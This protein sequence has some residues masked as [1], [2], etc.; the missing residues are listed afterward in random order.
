[1]SASL[2]VPTPAVPLPVPAL[3]IPPPASL[4]P[5]HLQPAPF[6]SPLLTPSASGQI[7]TLSVAVSAL[8]K[9]AV[10]VMV[11]LGAQRFDSRYFMPS[12][13]VL[14]TLQMQLFGLIAYHELDSMSVE[15][16]ALF[17]LFSLCCVA[18][19][20]IG[21]RNPGDERRWYLDMPNE[22]GSPCAYPADCNM[23]VA[24]FNDEGQRGME[25]GQRGN[26][27]RESRERRSVAC[28]DVP[29]HR[30]QSPGF[31]TGSPLAGRDTLETGMV[32]GW[33][34]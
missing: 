33:G 8:T 15:K 5:L 22:E 12:V 23:S 19:V 31:Q 17:A 2:I 18:S 27:S 16:H 4:L 10:Q 9:P 30:P 25:E 20:W 34:V 24:A 14:F 28:Q 21:S 6:S 13:M 29:A 11:S 1:M 3:P 7:L 26:E 32:A